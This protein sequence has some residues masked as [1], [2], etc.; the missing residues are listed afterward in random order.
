MLT[1]PVSRA[2]V[3]TYHYDN[4]RTGLNPAE[5]GLNPTSVSG[6]KQ[7]WFS[8]VDGDVYAQPLYI[9]SVVINGARHNELVVAT[10][11]DSVYA[12]DADTGSILWKTSLIPA[13]EVVVTSNCNDLPGTVGI[14]GTPVIDPV[15]NKV[16]AVAYTFN[17]TSGHKLYRLH[18][19]NLLT[20]ADTAST[21][22]AATFP[23]TFPAVDTSG[24]LVH[25]NAAEERQRAALLLFN[26][27]VYVAYASF[28]DFSPFTGWILAF[29]ENSL[30]LVST[31][32]IN[33]TKARVATGMTTLPDGSGGG[34]WGAEGALAADNTVIFATTG[35]GPWDGKTTFSDSILRL[36]PKTLSILDYFT[37]F[38]QALDQRGDLDLGSGGPVVLDTKDNG[39]TTHSLVVV[40]A[41][42]KKIYIADR[43]N[44]GKQTANN[45]GIYQVIG[46]VMPQPVFGPGAI[47]NGAMYWACG[48]GNPLEKFVFSNAKLSTTPA[49]KSTV[50]FRGEGAVPATSAFINSTGVVTGGLV[51][52]IQLTSIGLTL[53]AF[54]PGNLMTLFVGPT[55]AKP[56]TKFQVPTIANSK[57]YIG[58]VGAVTNTG[59][60]IF[61]FAGTATS[62]N[63]AVNQTTNP[64]VLLTPG[65]IIH[66]T[67]NA[68][69]QIVTVKNIGAKPLFTTP[70]SL[71]CDGLSSNATLSSASGATTYLTPLV[72]PYQHF[73]LSGPL[74][75]G[76]SVSLTLQFSSSTAG[77]TYK[78]RL[79]DGLGFR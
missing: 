37:P 40:A 78:A 26:G 61:A 42:D 8:Q 14:T 66:G 53:Y 45:S 19:L 15:K 72:S 76:H 11:K 36:D 16:F 9:S 51:W 5:T 64:S 1:P 27:N 32:D 18:S 33:P 56:G 20:G 68:Y 69:S 52:A 29:N 46:P 41:K 28:C 73:S 24:G 12:F 2:D 49:A 10:E 7:E 30:A 23:G 55:L 57:V 38:D 39:G 17:T 50:T 31:L 60:A 65:P 67:G 21:E 6:L 43:T 63:I 59:G 3:L 47:L 44:L 34:V 54:D 70:L 25:F 48:V 58:T 79:L 62:S 71:V 35:N 13:G 75:P 4:R 74:P 22:I 77:I